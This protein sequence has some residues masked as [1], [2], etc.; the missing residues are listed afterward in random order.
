VR[1]LT[2]H[3]GF[4]GRAQRSTVAL[5]LAGERTG[6]FGPPTSQ[7]AE[8]P[9][10]LPPLPPDASSVL[11]LQ[12]D[13]TFLYDCVL[14][15]LGTESET[16]PTKL[17]KLLGIDV[18]DDFLTAVGS[19]AV[20]YNS[21]GEGP[22][23]LGRSLAVQVKDGGKVEKALAAV[24]RALPAAL[25]GNVAVRKR[26]YRGATLYSLDLPRPFPPLPVRPAW[27]CHQ[28]WLVLSLFPQPVQ[29]FVLRSAG[30]YSVWKP[31]PL[32]ERL[33]AEMARYPQARILGWDE[34]DPR[35]GVKQLCQLGTFIAGVASA[36]PSNERFD[37][38]LVPNFQAITEPLFPDVTLFIAEGDTIRLESHASI[39]LL[40]ELAGLDSFLLLTVL[41]N[42]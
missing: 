6:L 8:R 5:H 11:T 20:L 28:G 16:E 38:A 23:I 7:R 40:M 42:F 12:L 32:G 18:R 29:G 26:T 35:P 4:E 25:G 9:V 19:A 21:P 30:K 22:F 27:T 39:N 3:F 33:R 1:E 17:D 37:V 10:A 36:F 31:S 2:L 14:E 15:A 41:G 34:T 24:A 13:P